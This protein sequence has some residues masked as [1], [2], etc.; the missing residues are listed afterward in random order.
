MDGKVRVRGSAQAKRI[1]LPHALQRGCTSLL[2]ELHPVPNMELP[3]Y[4][5]AI[6]SILPHS[7][8]T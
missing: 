6:G 8:G 5:F 1:F 7:L 4:F 2:G 3:D